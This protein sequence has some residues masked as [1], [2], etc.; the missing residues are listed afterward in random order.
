MAFGSVG[1][2]Q[3]P[4]AMLCHMAEVC[5]DSANFVCYDTQVCWGFDRYQYWLGAMGK[6]LVLLLLASTGNFPLIRGSLDRKLHCF[7]ATL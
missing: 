1:I 3:Y 2:A 6:S 4:L 7:V 5:R